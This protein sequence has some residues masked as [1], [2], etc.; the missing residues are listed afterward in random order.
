MADIQFTSV[1]KTYGTDV[2]ALEAFSLRIPSPT[3]VVLVGPSGCGKTTLLR[4]IAGLER[5]TTG[6]ITLGGD[7]LDTVDPR[8]R[9]VAMVFQNY[10]LYPHMTVRENLS[11]GLKIRK[12]P[13][14]VV[15]KKVEEVAVSLEINSL[16]DRRPAELSGGQRQR[17]A[18]GRAI[19]REPR[20]FLFDEPLS[21]LDARLR[22]EMRYL[23]KKLYRKLETTTIY[24]THDQVEAMTIGE[25]LVVLKDGKIHQVGSPS[26]CY[27]KPNDVFVASFLGSPPMNLLKGRF[28]GADGVVVIDNGAHLTLSAVARNSLEQNGIGEVIVGIRPESLHPGGHLGRSDAPVLTGRVVLRET[29]GHEVLTHVDLGGK[30]IVARGNARFEVDRDGMTFLEA[31]SDSLHFFGGRGGERL[32]VQNAE[33]EAWSS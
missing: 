30:E 11:F 5:P 28:S 15:V 32:G 14:D 8:R 1:T 16:L 3:L 29:L 10:A 31:P 25:M 27:E 4:L 22:D 2:V 6:T 7:R 23:I 19:I 17:V 12:V 18:L 24:V 13:R 20:V 21:N 33:N 26:E 9:D